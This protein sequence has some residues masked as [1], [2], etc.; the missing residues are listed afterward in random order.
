MKSNKVLDNSE[1]LDLI[2]KKTGCENDNQLAAYLTEKYGKEIN[3]QNINQF[4]K[5]SSMTVTSM[6]L[7]EALE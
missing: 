2:I 4:K 6:L 5:S 1:I 3:R 7:R